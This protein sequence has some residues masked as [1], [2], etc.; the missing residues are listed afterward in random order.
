MSLTKNLEFEKTSFLTK[1]NS[2]FIEQMYLRYINN[3]PELPDSWKNYFDDL[4]EELN[5]VANEL[6]GPTWSPIRKEIQIDFQDTQIKENEQTEEKTSTSENQTQSNI[7]SIKAVELIRAYRLRGHLLAKLDPLGLKQTEYL[8]ELH[9]EFYGFK[10]SDYKR[11]IFLNG[12]T[13]KKN[14][15]ISE[16]LQFVNKTY[17]GPIGYEYMHISNP[18]ERIWL[19]KRIEGEKNPISFT[20]NGKE[21][22][23]K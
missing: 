8:E 20:K 7:D 14:S 17:C 1:T 9:P 6:K 15:N 21:A 16:I 11:N 23:L 5:I 12:V 2:A 22:I 4:G 3:D 18:E 10:K 13:N 19:R